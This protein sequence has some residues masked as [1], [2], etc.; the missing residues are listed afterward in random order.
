MSNDAI[1]NWVEKAKSH[2]E[3]GADN[4]AGGVQVIKR[5][6]PMTKGNIIMEVAEKLRPWLTT[7]FANV[8]DEHG[9]LVQPAKVRAI[10]LNAAQDI[11]RKQEEKRN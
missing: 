9:M 1:N 10:A 11:V 4:R 8:R 6:V 3:N 7:L 2:T 5:A